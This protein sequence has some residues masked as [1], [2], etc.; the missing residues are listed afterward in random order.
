MQQSAAPAQ[1][2]QSS[3]KN[4]PSIIISAP[5]HNQSSTQDSPSII[6]SDQDANQMIAEHEPKFLSKGGRSGPERATSKHFDNRVNEL[7]GDVDDDNYWLPVQPGLAPG[8]VDKDRE[9]HRTEDRAPNQSSSKTRLSERLSTGLGLAV[10]VPTEIDY[11]G[12]NVP[13]K[14]ELLVDNRFASELRHISTTSVSDGYAEGHPSSKLCSDCQKFSASVLQPSFS[15]VYQMV[16]LEARSKGTQCDLCG[17]LWR[18]CERHDA[19][20]LPNVLLQRVG[21]SLRMNGMSGG[22]LSIFRSPGG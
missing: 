13:N 8:L 12:E 3:T 10:P 2:N 11:G 6:I 14:W 16:D 5:T 15:M 20:K 7:L 19:T 17:L 9:S 1:N 21:S 18:A 22:A 4:S